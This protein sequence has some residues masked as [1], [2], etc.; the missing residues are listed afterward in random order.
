LSG[1]NRK[2]P[3]S[4]GFKDRGWDVYAQTCG[5]EVPKNGKLGATRRKMIDVIR[6]LKF[7]F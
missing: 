1:K 2:T 3:A 5:G 4:K 7:D 6:D